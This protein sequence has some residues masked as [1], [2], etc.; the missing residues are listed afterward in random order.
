M[1]PV[2]GQPTAEAA[3]FTLNWLSATGSAILVAALIAGFS[4]R[5]S[6]RQLIVRYGRTLITVWR[7]LVTIAAFW[8]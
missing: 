4:L 5:Y 3:V 7:S 6:L 8:I 1:P 2:V